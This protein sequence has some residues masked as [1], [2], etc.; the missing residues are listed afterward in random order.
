M[1][2]FRSMFEAVGLRGRFASPTSKQLPYILFDL[3][4]LTNYFFFAGNANRPA[5][6]WKIGWSDDVAIRGWINAYIRILIRG[7]SPDPAWQR[8]KKGCRPVCDR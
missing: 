7:R 8:L 3:Q 6:R 2:F 5:A 4:S 1:T